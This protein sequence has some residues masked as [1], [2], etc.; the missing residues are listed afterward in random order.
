M[1][2]TPFG[3]EDYRTLDFFVLT[4]EP[5]DVDYHE[6][7]AGGVPLARLSRPRDDATGVHHSRVTEWRSD[8][9]RVAVLPFRS[10]HTANASEAAMATA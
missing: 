1:T 3:I 2:G 5:A 4:G 9:N 8:G 10:R 6:V 7:D